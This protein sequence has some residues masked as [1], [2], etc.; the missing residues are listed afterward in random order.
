METGEFEEEMKAGLG[1]R[2]VN[3]TV[4]HFHV[5]APIL[6]YTIYTTADSYSNYLFHMKPIQ[7]VL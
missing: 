1:D 4:L 5:A 3:Y 2:L 7:C 6:E